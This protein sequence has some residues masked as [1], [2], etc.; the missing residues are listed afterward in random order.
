[1]TDLKDGQKWNDIYSAIVTLDNT[2]T[3]SNS[4]LSDEEQIEDCFPI[5]IFGRKRGWV[6]QTATISQ[7]MKAELR[8]SRS[9]ERP[10]IVAVNDGQPQ[11]QINNVYRWT[12]KRFKKLSEK[13]IAK[14]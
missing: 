14:L 3:R 8:Y 5:E 12:G 2:I 10:N 11:I 13:E 7:P 9:L 4:T 1:M 6:F